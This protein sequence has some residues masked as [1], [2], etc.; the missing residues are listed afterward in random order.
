M[1]ASLGKVLRRRC[2]LEMKFQPQGHLVV[3]SAASSGGKLTRCAL[4]VAETTKGFK[5]E[6]AGRGGAAIG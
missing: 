2:S 3:P 1:R 5:S 4:P 6:G